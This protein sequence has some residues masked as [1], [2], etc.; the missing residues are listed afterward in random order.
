MRPPVEH[1]RVNTKDKDI[2]V[3]VKRNTGLEHWNEICRLALCV[4]LANPT[5]PSKTDKVPDSNIDIEWKTFAGNYHDEFISLILHRAHKDG[6]DTLDKNTLANY[7]RSHLERGI[8]A[9]H[10]VKNTFDLIVK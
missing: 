9:L 6:I 8:T 4:S 7:F 2:L 1:V 5:L 3:K 10:H